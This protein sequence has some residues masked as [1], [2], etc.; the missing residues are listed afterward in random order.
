MSEQFTAVGW[1]HKEVEDFFMKE[2]NYFYDGQ[3]I[4]YSSGGYNAVY[5]D[6]DWESMAEALSSRDGLDLTNKSEVTDC[7]TDLM[8]SYQ[9]SSWG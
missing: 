1:T 9:I 8:Y 4:R 7:L 3:G 5:S 6:P 2:G